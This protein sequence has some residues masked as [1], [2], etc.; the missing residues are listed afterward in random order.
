MYERLPVW[1]T[2]NNKGNLAKTARGLRPFSG[3]DP[4]RFENRY[5]NLSIILRMSRPD[6]TQCNGSARQDRPR[7]RLTRRRRGATPL[8]ALPAA[9]GTTSAQHQGTRDRTGHEPFALL[10]LVTG[11]STSYFVN[12]HRKGT[13]ATLVAGKKY[14]RSCSAST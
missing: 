6:M 7:R 4:T 8:S 5:D 12:K 11:E 2:P 3:K 1:K 10:S 9:P 14:G 13:T